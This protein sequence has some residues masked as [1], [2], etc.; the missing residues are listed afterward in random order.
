MPHKIRTQDKEKPVSPLNF[1]SRSVP[2]PPK[3]EAA[4]KAFPLFGGED[5]EGGNTTTTG[6]QQNSTTQPAG[7][8]ATQQSNST[9]TQNGGNDQTVE[10]QAKLDKAINDLAEANKSIKNFEKKETD[11]Q[12]ATQT[13][14]Q[15]LQTDLDTANQTIAQMDA[16][17]RHSALVNAVQG[18]K[19][20]EFHSVRHVINEL[21][22]D[23]FD[24][25]V[26]LEKG[27]ATVTGIEDAIKRIAAK[28]PWLIKQ[29]DAQDQNNGNGTPRAPK[30]GSGAPPVG[31]GGAT[32]GM[33]A[34]K[35][36]AMMKRFPVIGMG[37]RV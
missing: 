6:E 19:N 10:L 20:Y 22:D 35:R 21:Q 11:A 27:V 7:G 16:I 1:A 13:R 25:D 5:E 28:E 33:S 32:K 34:E 26:D 31:G 17:I 15:N 8:S 23:E 9:T 30:P 18:L 36:A 4:L 12:R 29:K 14:E 37:R 2:T 24:V 3:L